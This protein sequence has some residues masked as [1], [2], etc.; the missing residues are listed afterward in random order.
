MKKFAIQIILLLAVVFGALFLFYNQNFLSSVVPENQTQEQ[1]QI[2]IND[3]TIAI[4]VAD[5][6]SKR[7]KGLSG[8]DS[9]ASSSGMLFVFQEEKKYRFWMKDMKF[10]LD[11]IFINKSKVVDI[12]KNV[13]PSPSGMKDSDLSVYEPIS[14]IDMLLEVNSGFADS[15]NI[16]VGDQ[17]YLVK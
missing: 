9:L 17:V 1:K 14:A 16:K 15:H 7:N 13:Q 11:F 8:R 4:E 6:S 5:T 10:P 12:I 3:N 2:K